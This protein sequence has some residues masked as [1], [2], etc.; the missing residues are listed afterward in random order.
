MAGSRERVD[1]AA[2]HRRAAAVATAAADALGAAAP[3][4]PDPREQYELAERLRAA[5]QAL[6]PGWLGAPLDAQPQIPLG[7][8]PP[9]FV[10]L[11]VAQ[12]LDDARFPAVVPL[13]GA[14][15]LTVD[16][17][18]RDPRVTGLLRSVLLRLLAA[19]PAGSVLVRAV[20]GA[21]GG[22][23]FAPFAAL[24]DAGLLAPP[25]TDRAGLRT[26][27][28]EAEQWVRPAR[29]ASVRP[30]RRERTM[31]VVVASLPELTEGA[32]LTRLAAL[33]QHGP[34]AN[35]HMV[36]AGW[37]P[38]P[39]TAETTQPPL[40]R[41]T[42]VA[43]KNPFAFVSDP[44]GAAFSEVAAAGGKVGWLNSPVY[45]DEDPPATL[46]DRVCEEL[47][48][49]S[50]VASQVTLAD[51]LPEPGEGLWAGD[52][53]DGLTTIV[54]HDGDRSVTL[55][56]NDLT[57][58]WLV[59][60]RSGAGKT[61][62]LINVLYGLGSRYS[63]GELALYLLD[64]KEGVSFTEFV[65]TPRDRTWLP[66]ARAVGVESDREY[67]LA[68][69][70]EL[71]AEM[72]R[73]S[74][75]Y[76]RA[77][78]SKFADLRAAAAEEGRPHRLPRVLCVIDEFQVLLAGSDP[79]AAEAVALLESLA[80]KGRSYGIHL[81]LASQTVLG[82]EA[83][84][85]K[86]DSIFGQFPVRVA[87]PGGGDVLEPTND[88]AAGLALGTAVINTA[89]GLGGPRG[90][91]RGHERVVQF[92]DPHAD[93]AELLDLRHRLWQERDADAVPPRVFAGYARQ[94]LDDDPTFRAALAGR[95]GRPAALLGR[96]IDVNLSTAAFPLDAS[97]GRHLAVFGSQAVGAEVLQ[98]AAR[99][100]AAHHAPRTARFVIASLVAEGDE[101]A[102]Q[103]AVEVGQSQEVS[104]IEAADL[105]EDLDATVPGYRIV[106]GMDAAKLPTDRLRA[107]LRDGP[108]NGAH[109]LS[110]W[111]GTRR[112]T[113]EVG[114]S[115]AREDVAG[116]L[117]LNVPGADV[118]LLL[119]RPVD[120]HPRE[121]RALLH[122]RHADRTTVIVPF[123]A[124]E[125]D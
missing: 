91:T 2:L 92:P 74:V 89:G 90:A 3:P 17:D 4:P 9:R 120:W 99:G 39:L 125:R 103:L 106:F 49:Q 65:P 43:V 55:R 87:L 6:A 11:G 15:H 40:P 122:D 76:K 82:V 64:F 112:F 63:P 35:L 116:M 72:T 20:D 46:V 26:L 85:A 101:L 68:V 107:L 27:L 19:A 58:H 102:K 57:P 115:A 37:P 22:S 24:E 1:A 25:A 52:A 79:M 31:L 34:D 28:T 105:A 111:R 16:A 21:G 100:V 77:G 117:F 121:N 98:A 71:E 60:G 86:R 95:A 50:A 119:G 54:G 81:V 53:A 94:H 97:P 29:S 83:L 66:H 59:G 108:A 47:A 110:W 113:E 114:G 96:T 118:G 41:A 10:R 45:L 8:P 70:R 44:P 80:R 38:P 69:L 56:F 109:L 23:V 18:A 123:A 62:F 104:V 48:A 42:M 67:G 32:D 61:A 84:Y 33:A 75:A 124:P 51:V 36:V 14:G 5:A 78:V 13:L 12:P 88:S 93:R 30:S 7:G 73:R